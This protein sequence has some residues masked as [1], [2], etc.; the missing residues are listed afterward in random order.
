[1][2]TLAPGCFAS[3]K[4][5]GNEEF[6]VSTFLEYLVQRHD[7]SLFCQSSPKDCT[8]GLVVRLGWRNSLF[9]VLLYCVTLDIREIPY[10]S[11]TPQVRVCRFRESISHAIDKD[12]SN[13]KFRVKVLGCQTRSL[14]MRFFYVCRIRRPLVCA[15]ETPTVRSAQIPWRYRHC[16]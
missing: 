4:D 5:A 1:M 2:H 8:M 9:H 3:I 11:L 13:P 12:P 14:R 15:G 16:C 6:F 7:S 10:A